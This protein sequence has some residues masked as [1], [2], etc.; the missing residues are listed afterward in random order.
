MFK[1]IDYKV[2]FV[3]TPVR[4]EKTLEGKFEFGLG[5][6]AILGPNGKGKSL[7]LEMAQ[8]ALFGSAAL[9]GKADT[10]KRIEVSLTFIIKQ[11]E[12]K[13]T[14]IGSAVK[15]FQGELQLATGTKP[16]NERVAKLFGYSYDVFKV[17]NISQQGEIEKLGSMLPTARKKL[18]DET[19][20][21]NALD[22]LST[23]IG[24]EA[25][26][27]SA[28]I[29][30][31]E[32]LVVAPEA[33]V[34]PEGLQ[35]PK[36]YQDSLATFNLL[37]QRRAVFQ[38][39]ANKV[40]KP[41]TVPELHVETPNLAMYQQEV[42]RRT[43]LMSQ[44]TL[45]A[46]QKAAIPV[47]AVS[48]EVARHERHNDLEYL[49]NQKIIRDRLTQDQTN[50]R[51]EFQRLPATE[52]TLGYLIEQEDLHLQ[53]TRVQQKLK[54]KEKNVPHDCPACKHH[55]EDADPR[56]ETEFKQVPDVAPVPA[57]TMQQIASA[58]LALNHADRRNELLK[59]IADADTNLQGTPDHTALIQ[60]IVA[61]EKAY[62]AAETARANQARLVELDAQIKV[63]EGQ[64]EATVD[65]AGVIRAIQDAEQARRIAILL[66]DQ[67]DVAFQEQQVAKQE[68]AAIP[69][70]LDT[71]IGLM[72][73]AL[74][75]A[76]AYLL[77]QK[78]YEED[79]KKFEELLIVLNGHKD[80]LEDWKKGREA[81]TELRA[82]VKGYIVPALNSVSSALLNEMTG[83]E[84]SQV[85]TTE[86]MEITVDGDALETLS[87]AGKGVANLALRLALGQVL[88]NS[89]FPTVCLDEV[90]SSFDDQRA[91]Y[92]ANCLRRLTKVYKQVLL[93]SHKPSVEADNYI[94][95]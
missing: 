37:L 91:E 6:T 66:K 95:L 10:Y 87:G 35:E 54:L 8:Y 12:Y 83:G 20:G 53:V 74:Q 69:A 3:A 60:E 50:W 32:P 78:R 58:R 17:A 93:I 70:D 57:L 49:R 43:A 38:A 15:L 77:H 90:D 16:V 40:L 68:L 45:L 22:E 72:Q 21:L 63:V 52:H 34:K 4:P 1:D 25:T 62:A 41:V 86:D 33:P 71:N 76:Q 26:T 56:L 88:T 23:Y 36:V 79:L 42:E 94:R 30:A 82:K 89:V 65:R 64:F 81:V 67:Y 31:L 7:V 39:A 92:T 29:R 46:G 59:L 13:A 27:V 73:T 14:R 47:A 5:L 44:Y 28:T 55:W 9:R 80:D 48:E 51:A 19:I 11:V 24:K 85:V 75:E 18:I 84:L 2:T 61:S